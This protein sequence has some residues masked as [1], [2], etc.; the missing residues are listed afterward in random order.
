MKTDAISEISSL[1]KSHLIIGVLIVES[2]P[3]SL[4]QLRVRIP[5]LFGKTKQRINLGFI[6]ER[7]NHDSIIVRWFIIFDLRF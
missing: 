4:I 2:P 5:N 6:F 1:K 3:G 7:F